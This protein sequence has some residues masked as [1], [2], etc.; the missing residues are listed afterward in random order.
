MRTNPDWIYWTN[1]I[2]RL[3][4]GLLMIALVVAWFTTLGID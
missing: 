2:M 1:V 4:C 3:F